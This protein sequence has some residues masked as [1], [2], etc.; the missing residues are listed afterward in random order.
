MNLLVRIQI[1]KSIKVQKTK[2]LWNIV[3]SIGTYKNIIEYCDII[4]KFSKGFS[5]NE[6]PY[7]HFGIQH[8]NYYNLLE[9]KEI[10]YLSNYFL[11]NGAK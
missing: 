8:V 3:D 1:L 10:L 2:M 11:L 9:N 4:W 7:W 5:L 6:P